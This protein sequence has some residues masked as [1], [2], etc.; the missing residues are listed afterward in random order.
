MA[1]GGN[2]RW[3]TARSP[4]AAMHLK[5]GRGR[6]CEAFGPP[7]FF[8]SR[9]WAVEWAKGHRA[10]ANGTALVRHYSRRPTEIVLVRIVIA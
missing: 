2:A 3:W 6:G 5:K 8:G 4:V 9:G 1:H 10:T 7:K